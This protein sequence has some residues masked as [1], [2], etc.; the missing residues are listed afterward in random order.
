MF[1]TNDNKN[2][3]ERIFGMT[4]R[5]RVYD[6]HFKSK[7]RRT[8]EAILQSDFFSRKDKAAKSELIYDGKLTSIYNP[9]C[10]SKS[11]KNLGFANI[12]NEL[13]HSVF[14]AKLIAR[15]GLME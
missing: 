14:K 7:V 13:N 6:Q 11:K 4:V 5:P 2:K 1:D 10:L 8:Q 9:T 12:F 15:M 3:F